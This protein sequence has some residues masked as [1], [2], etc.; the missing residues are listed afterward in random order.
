MRKNDRIHD[1][2]ECD[3]DGGKMGQE[4]KEVHLTG[5]TIKGMK[6]VRVDV[7]EGKSTTGMITARKVSREQTT[8][9][10]ALPGSQQPG[11]YTQRAT[12][13]Q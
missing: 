8:E 12:S 3:G 1:I 4:R 11:R 2:Q 9:K 5:A 6:A 7:I 10:A 13:G